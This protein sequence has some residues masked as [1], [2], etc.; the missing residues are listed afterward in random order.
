VGACGAGADGTGADVVAGAL[1]VPGAGAAGVVAGGAPACGA[2]LALVSP[3]VRIPPTAPAH[4]AVAVKARTRRA[5]T[6]NDMVAEVL[7]AAALRY[8]LTATAAYWRMW[9]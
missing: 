5:L 8:E 4:R 2:A 7:F 6:D 9:R 1:S 3:N